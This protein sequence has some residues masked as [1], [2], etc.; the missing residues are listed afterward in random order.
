MKREIVR[1]SDSASRPKSEG[2]L[3]RS[4]QPQ[5]QNQSVRAMGKGNLVLCGELVRPFGVKSMGNTRHFLNPCNPIV[6]RHIDK[7]DSGHRQYTNL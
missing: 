3:L 1:Q 6:A 5:I 4:L 2:L 7:Q